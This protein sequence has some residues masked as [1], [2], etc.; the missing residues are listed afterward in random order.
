MTSPLR[1]AVLLLAL[2]G[3]SP[4]GVHVEP[5]ATSVQRPS[6]I[7]VYVAVDR[8]RDPLTQLTAQ[9]FRLY[10]DGQLLDAEETQLRVLPREAAAEHRALLLLDVTGASTS[11]ERRWL[12]QAAARFVR[13]VRQLEPVAVYAFDGSPGLHRIEEYPRQPNAAEPTAI[14]PL[15]KLALRD[16]SR[17]LNGAV[18]EGLRTLD[19]L[20][21]TAEKPVRVGTLVVVG[22]GPDLAGRVARGQVAQELERTRHDVL[23]ITIGDKQ[24]GLPGLGRSGVLHADALSTAGPVFERAAAK[25]RAVHSS[26]YLLAYCSPARGGVRELR[27]E[28]EIPD[29]RGRPVKGWT[30]LEFS[31]AGFQPGCDSQTPPSFVVTL[32]SLDGDSVPGA[33]PAHAEPPAPPEAAPSEAEAEATA[34]A[35]TRP[36]PKPKR[37]RRPRASRPRPGPAPAPAPAP[38]PEP[39][40]E[41]PAKP[42]K[43]APSPPGEPPDFEP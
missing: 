42:A 31:A 18:V 30:E 7:A 36:E 28:V 2:A 13:S 41:T 15:E 16:R 43:P 22:A 24:I 17:N 21:T 3:C 35:E 1:V 26:H 12:S 10:E 38:K 34:E 25:V 19:E 4:Q 20:L 33:T 8:K 29:A 9:N 5:V 32:V 11:V 27:I 6:N 14:E 39:K 23:A 37:R 40:P